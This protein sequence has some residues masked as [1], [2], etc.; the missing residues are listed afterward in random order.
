MK[1]ILL[2]LI[3]GILICSCSVTKTGSNKTRYFDE[4]NL[5]ISKS[6]FNRIRSTNKMLDIPGDSVNHKKLTVREKRGK[7]N[8]RNNL[9]V[10]LE[11]Q[12]NKE[13]K[14]N[15]PI[16][17]V[18]YPGEDSCNKGGPADP[19]MHKNYLKK[20]IKG[21]YNITN[22]TPLFIY[23]DYKGLENRSY[24]EIFTW[25]KD[26]NQIVEKLFFKYHYPCYS[27]V[28]V[29]ADGE[30][31]SYFGEFTKENIWNSAYE[32]VN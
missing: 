5:E 20:I 25:Q 7:I 23:K 11:N 16:V 13:I 10:L 3:L 22:T 21:L 27:Y 9:E 18:Y 2:T 31:I 8:N 15:K 24:K 32:I 26:P 30:Y 1:K 28:I 14:S 29:G 17:I 12:I 6:K 19:V 4:N